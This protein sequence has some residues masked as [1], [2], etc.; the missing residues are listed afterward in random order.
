MPVLILLGLFATGAARADEVA[1]PSTPA[2]VQASADRALEAFEKMDVAQFKAEQTGASKALACLGEPLSPDQ[3]AAWHR[4]MALA[5]F[6]DRDQD[7]A[8]A[9]FQ[10]SRTI[11]AEA[12][13]PDSI[14]PEGHPLDRLFSKADPELAGAIEPLAVPDGGKA[15]VDGSP[16][17]VVRPIDRPSVLQL[18]GPDGAVVDTRDL[19]AR[20]PAPDWSQFAFGGE[21]E[22]TPEPEPTQPAPTPEPVARAGGP[23]VGLTVAA[24][25]AAATS[26]ATFAAATASRSKFDDPS[27]A[28]ADLE[29]LRGRTNGLAAVSGVAAAGAVGL[30]VAAVT[31]S[32]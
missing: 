27:T 24:G 9:R 3:A 10:A 2:D 16:D 7:A 32:F 14:A 1:C 30:G 5:A 22:P 8:V 31:V 6:L 21:P 19:G 15:W 20:A 23:H 17:S 29:G 28:Y 13:L 18:A 11:D 25:V 12:R 4:L 26:A